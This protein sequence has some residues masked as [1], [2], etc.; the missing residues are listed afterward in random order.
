MAILTRASR[1]KVTRAAHAPGL[2]S[3][4]RA[5]VLM[6]VRCGDRQAG[7]RA[8][9]EAYRTPIPRSIGAPPG[10]PQEAEDVTQE[11]FTALL[12]PGY[13][14]GFDPARGRFRQWLRGCA[15]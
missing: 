8:L 15:R 7:L 1:M 11:L 3:R 9:C 5:S 4:T 2:W 13:L 12:R 14:D 10:D 6:R